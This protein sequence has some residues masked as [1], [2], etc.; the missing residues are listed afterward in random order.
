M[1]EVL[2]IF[3]LVMLAINIGTSW[4]RCKAANY[5]GF[6]RLDVIIWKYDAPLGWT[7]ALIA[8]LG[9]IGRGG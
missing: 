4:Q 1:N 5:T 8:W 3:T 2:H 9:Y 7:V 6:S